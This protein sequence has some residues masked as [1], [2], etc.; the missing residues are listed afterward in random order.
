MKKFFILLIVL[1]AL[2]IFSGIVSC[3]TAPSPAPAAAPSGP[4]TPPPPQVPEHTAPV[5]E[6]SLAPEFFSPDGDGV[7]DTLQIRIRVRT[8]SLI[9]DWRMEIREPQPPYPVFHELSGRGE[10]PA[11]LTWNGKSSSGELVQSASDYPF[12]ITVTDINGNSSDYDGIIKVDVLVIRDPNGALR[13]QVPSIVFAGYSGNLTGLDAATTANNDYILR[14]IAEALKKF[15]NYQIKVEGHANHTGAT[16][17]AR[18]RE[19]A[20]LLALSDQRARTVMDYLIRLGIDRSRLSAVGIGGARPV[21]RFEDRDNWW[22]NRR[23][24]FILIK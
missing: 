16:A 2:I 24:E 21:A 6:V 9:R 18:Q 10:P 7:D 17:A 15:N 4:P 14:R 12:K 5:I 20:E 8:E 1:P 19:T 3:G 13:I 23:V 22:K 11:N